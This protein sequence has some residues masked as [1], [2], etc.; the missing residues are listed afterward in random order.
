MHWCIYGAGAIGGVV[1][2][3]LAFLGENVTFIARGEHLERMQKSGLVLV[4]PEGTR[5]VPVT[6]SS[7]PADAALSSGDIVILA[8]KSQHTADAL[9]DLVATVPAGVRIFC[10][11]NGIDNERQALRFFADVHGVSVTLL[12]SFTEPGTV[13]A[14]SAPTVGILQLG[15]AA[16]GTDEGTTLAAEVLRRAGLR[17]DVS[18]DV[19][20]YK[21]LK[22]IRNLGNAIEIVCSG[23]A[24]ALLERMTTE[25]E[26]VFSKAGFTLPASDEVVPGPEPVDP[27]VPRLGGSTLQSLLRASG[28]IETDFLNGEIAMLGRIYSI[29]TPVNVLM[30]QLARD[31]ATGFRFR[32]SLTEADVLAMLGD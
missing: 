29:P 28:S 10:M 23:P 22:L 14:H 15:L 11:Q 12:A 18:D 3:R 20:K 27:S 16:G 7:S 32:Q 8:V 24:P 6:A 19:M 13:V 31:A 5:L 17:V 9:A 26:G 1:G 2:A 30:Q 25:A 21:R 4:D